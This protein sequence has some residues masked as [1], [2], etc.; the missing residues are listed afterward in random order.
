VQSIHKLIG[1]N[2]SQHQTN[3]QAF[4]YVYLRL[5]TPK[6]Q[7]SLIDMLLLID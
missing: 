6:K 2:H 1:L 7:Q 5:N 4:W 3:N